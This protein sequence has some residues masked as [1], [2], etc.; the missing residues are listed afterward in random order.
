MKAPLKVAVIGAG[1]A[2]MAAA[3]TA[4]RIG[5]VATVF[6]ATKSTGGRARL[7]NGSLP[8]GSP[9]Q[10]DNGQH[11]LIG[12]YSETLRLMRCVGLEPHNLLLRQPLSLR[13]SDGSG[14]ACPPWP[15]PL[16]VVAGIASARGWTWADKL[17]LVRRAI[18]WRMA[19]FTCNPESTVACVCQGVSS[20]V[21]TELIEPLCVSALNTPAA[22][23]SGSVFL[24][25][26]K[27]SL[28]A[29][30]KVH[31]SKEGRQGEVA[32][33]SSDFLLPLCDLSALFPQPAALWLA[34]NGSHV[35]MGTRVT[36][37]KKANGAGDV[38]AGGW[39]VNGEPFDAVIMAVSP[40][41]SAIAPVFNQLLAIPSIANSILKWQAQVEALHFEA[42]TTVY[43]FSPQATLRQPVLAL[44]SGDAAPAQFVFDRGQLGS[45]RGLMAFVVSASQGDRDALQA[46]VFAQGQSA[47]G[48]ALQPVQTVVEKRATF[49]CTPGLARPPMQIAPGLLACGDYIDGPYPA[50][51]EGAV[52]SGVA[53]A[54]ALAA[55]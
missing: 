30:A 50:T 7:L 37:I 47:L 20:R 4:T 13:Y 34:Q 51:L 40:Q 6:E 35:R 36:E 43:A 18:Q 46:Q 52:R 12:A 31:S 23:A 22:Q 44:R 8:D 5:H 11:I 2:G 17:S 16:N 19:G 29:P 45:P 48:L 39:L 28:F 53:A 1:W 38:T 27:D 33:A 26:M 54:N 10:L 55:A 9:V 42:I 32:F 14:L 25:V 49:A 41:I 15:A 3:V 21:M 24:R